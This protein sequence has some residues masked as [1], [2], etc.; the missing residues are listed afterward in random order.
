MVAKRKA[1]YSLSVACQFTWEQRERSKELLSR[2][3]Y[4]GYYCNN[5]KYLK[6]FETYIPYTSHKKTCSLTTTLTTTVEQGKE[7]N[8]TFREK[9]RCLPTTAVDDSVTLI[10]YIVFLA[11]KPKTPLLFMSLDR[12]QYQFGEAGISR[13][14]ILTLISKNSTLRKS[15][16]TV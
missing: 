2:K 15:F 7:S 8:K 1:R 9:T 14:C 5:F 10:K 4:Y 13:S 12:E 11:A 6:C 16:T 3:N